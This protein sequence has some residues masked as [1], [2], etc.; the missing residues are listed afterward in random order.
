MK[1]LIAL[2]LS[3][4]FFVNCSSLVKMK[5]PKVSLANLKV[6]D[7]DLKGA[8]LVFGV[9]VENPNNAELKVDEVIYDLEVSGKSISSG[10]IDRDLRVSANATEIIN[11]PI[12]VKYSD[13]FNS[14]VQLLA[15]ETSPYRIKGSARFGLFNIPFDKQG[16][17][18]FEKGKLK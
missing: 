1:F 2:A 10:K 4:F 9:Q 14:L 18:K 12:A 5:E 15:N 11:V 3:L 17:L 16:E 7:P 13:L 8:T 6:Q